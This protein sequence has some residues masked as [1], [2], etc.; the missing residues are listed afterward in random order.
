METLKRTKYESNARVHRQKDEK[1]RAQRDLERAKQIET[2]LLRTIQDK[3]QAL[4][5]YVVCFLLFVHGILKKSG[6]QS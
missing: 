1:H 3:E 6:Q 2:D 5:R 4:E